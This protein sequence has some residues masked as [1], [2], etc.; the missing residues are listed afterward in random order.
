MGGGGGPLGGTLEATWTTLADFT[1]LPLLEAVATAA[2]VTLVTSAPE[3]GCTARVVGEEQPI[4]PSPGARRRGG[5][6]P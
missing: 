2:A 3:L 5:G 6:A 1:N 4:P